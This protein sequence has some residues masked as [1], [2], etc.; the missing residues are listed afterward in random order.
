MNLDIN[1][2]KNESGFTSYNQIAEYLL[3][4]FHQ[5]T[6]CDEMLEITHF[7]KANNIDIVKLASSDEIIPFNQPK[8]RMSTEEI[9]E[10]IEEIIKP[11]DVTPPVDD[12][13]KE[14]LD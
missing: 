12:K 4:L 1:K 2:L 3:T 11:V 13:V 10:N 14:I 7:A 9:K 5:S 6:S 8:Q